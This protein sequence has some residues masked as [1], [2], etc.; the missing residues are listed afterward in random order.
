MDLSSG[1]SKIQAYKTNYETKPG[2]MT[3]EMSDKEC[4][5]LEPR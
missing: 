1:P 5:L 3:N 2:G 4:C